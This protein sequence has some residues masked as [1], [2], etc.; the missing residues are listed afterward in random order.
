ML[1]LACPSGQSKNNAIYINIEINIDENF[2]YIANSY[3]NLGVVFYKSIIFRE[4]I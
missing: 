3:R 4:Q 2:I 1:Y